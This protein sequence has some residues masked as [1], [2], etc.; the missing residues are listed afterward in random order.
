M[1]V[2]QL[3]KHRHTA[4]VSLQRII[5]MEQSIPFIHHPGA[6]MR[7][8]N[9]AK[10]SW[11]WQSSTYGANVASRAVDGNVDPALSAGSC[12]QTTSSG[13]SIWAVDTEAIS[14]V[15][16]VDVVIC[17]TIGKYS[18]ALRISVLTHWGRDKMEAIS[19]TAF[20]SA[21]SWMKM[22]AFRLKFHWS[23]FLKVQLKIF[24]HWFR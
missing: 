15:Q 20:W 21:F 9:V 13:D 4:A 17:D 18:T 22:F 14:D 23:L 11:A 1:F 3:S 7:R 24:Q 5:S 10:G 2:T 12:S 6:H 19:Q 8:T 16:S